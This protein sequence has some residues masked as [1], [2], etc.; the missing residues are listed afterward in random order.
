MSNQFNYSE[1]DDWRLQIEWANL[2]E[3]MA[4]FTE[5]LKVKYSEAW[6]NRTERKKRIR[7]RI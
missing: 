6:K 5:E 2:M 7:N 4:T 1:L 3:G